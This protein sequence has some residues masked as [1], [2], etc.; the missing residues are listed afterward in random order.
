[1]YPGFQS[2]RSI[3]ETGETENAC[4]LEKDPPRLDMFP[5]T[6]QVPWKDLVISFEVCSPARLIFGN[7]G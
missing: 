6:T 3:R 5:L 2:A 7:I 4:L 1:M